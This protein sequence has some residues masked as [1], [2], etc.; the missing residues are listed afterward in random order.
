ML[1]ITRLTRTP[2]HNSQPL[3]TFPKLPCSDPFETELAKI[4]TPGILISDHVRRLICD[5]AKGDQDTALI[6]YHGL[7]FEAYVLRE[8]NAE[9]FV[10]Q[11]MYVGLDTLGAIY[12][13]WPTVEELELAVQ[14]IQR[15]PQ[16]SSVRM[17]LLNLNNWTPAYATRTSAYLRMVDEAMPC[18]AKHLASLKN[19]VDKIG[20]GA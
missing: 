18:S 4:E 5:Q 2:S 3:A 14:I 17:T 13:S 12:R 1:P 19:L 11:G 7:V 16:V 20:V 10:D 9:K 8:A 15:D 6:L